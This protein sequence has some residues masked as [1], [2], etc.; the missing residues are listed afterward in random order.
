[1]SQLSK[2]CVLILHLC[3][4]EFIYQFKKLQIWKYHVGSNQDDWFHYR[5]GISISIRDTDLMKVTKSQD[6]DL[7]IS[8][9]ATQYDVGRGVC[10]IFLKH[11]PLFSQAN[12]PIQLVSNNKKLIMKRKRQAFTGDVDIQFHMVT[13]HIRVSLFF[14]FAYSV[15]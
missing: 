9:Q 14:L 6:L 13:K 1:M 15:F 8:L 7:L 2:A 10:L 4:L 12:Q 11:T 3:K 5:Q